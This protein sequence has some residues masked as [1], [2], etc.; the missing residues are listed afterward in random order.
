MC[1]EILTQHTHLEELE[2]RCLLHLLGTDQVIKSTSL[3]VIGFCVFYEGAPQDCIK[4][5]SIYIL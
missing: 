4:C 2:M 1:M 3:L 5:F